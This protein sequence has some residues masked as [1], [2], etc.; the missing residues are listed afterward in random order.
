MSQKKTTPSDLNAAAAALGRKG[1]LA[2][3]KKLTPAERKAIGKQLA[4]ARKQIPPEERKRIAK[5]AVAKREEYRRE[6]Q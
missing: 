5:A 3:A 1:G 6:K 2:K 4:E